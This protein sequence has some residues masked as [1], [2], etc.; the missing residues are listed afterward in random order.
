MPIEFSFLPRPLD[1]KA[2]YALDEVVM[3]HA[4]DIH[5]ELGRFCDERIYQ[6]ELAYRCAA[7]GFE[8]LREPMIAVKHRDFC[9]QYFL[10]LLIQA[11]S[12]YELKAANS[13]HG[14]HEAQLI[15]YLLL[16]KLRHG[17]LINMRTGSVEYRYV[18]TRLTETDRQRY[19]FNLNEWN[20]TDPAAI[21]LQCL[22]DDLLSDWGAFL[23]IQLYREALIHFLGGIDQVVKPMAIRVGGRFVGTQQISFIAEDIAFHLSAIKI[24]HASYQTHMNRFL[25]HSS[26]KKI[27]WVNFHGSEI[28][29][30]TLERKR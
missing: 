19:T 4:F 30:K 13:L 8:V 5:N 11:G 15:N 2:F 7:S 29:L 9:K 25:E 28:Q 12:I 22:L 26:I 1:Q 3:R 6:E 17:K 14:N 10:D 16:S 24:H 27:H 20:G 21:S 23:E 18:S